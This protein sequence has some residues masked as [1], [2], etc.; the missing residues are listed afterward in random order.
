MIYIIL[1]HLKILFISIILVANPFVLGYLFYYM[2]N[3]NSTNVIM[4][5]TIYYVWNI[6]N[7]LPNVFNNK[8]IEHLKDVRK[9]FRRFIFVSFIIIFFVNLRKTIIIELIIINFIFFILV[10]IDF[11]K[12]WRIIHYPFFKKGTWIFPTDSKIIQCFPLSFW[13]KL[14]VLILLIYDLF[15]L[16]MTQY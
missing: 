6:T 12:L 10:L 3:N 13:F 7:T 15:L 8:E 2:N 11:N 1:F 9:L 16:I 14:T 4:M 5:A